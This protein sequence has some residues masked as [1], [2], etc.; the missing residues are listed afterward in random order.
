MTPP[1]VPMRSGD[2]L[3]ETKLSKWAPHSVEVNFF[4]TC[5]RHKQFSQNERRRADKQNVASDFLT[6]APGLCDE[7]SKFSDN[8]TPFF[9]NTITKS[10]GKN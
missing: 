3:G 9:R 6:F 2:H 8:F 10:Q 4:I 7:L 5:D 1:F